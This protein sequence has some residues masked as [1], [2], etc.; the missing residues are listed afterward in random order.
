M[1]LS[2]FL[3]ELVGF[4]FV[5]IALAMLADSKNIKRVFEIAEDETKAFFHGVLSTVAGI[6][7]LLGHNI[8]VKDWTVIVTIFGWL[9]FIKGVM[10]LFMPDMAKKWAGKFKD[11]QMTQIALTVVVI[12][13]CALV[14]LGFTA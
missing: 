8:W 9:M 2:N 6:A 11:N 3:A 14:Y 4:S 7:I 5:I 10:F 1:V 13:G 12:I